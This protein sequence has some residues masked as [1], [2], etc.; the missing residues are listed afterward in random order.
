MSAQTNGAP[1]AV[2]AG[3]KP[4]LATVWLGG[5]SGCHM[6]LLDL[7]ERLLDLAKAADVVFSPVVDI[8]EFP[9]DV[10]VTLVEGAVANRDHVDMIK[11]VRERS[12]LVV[13]F[14]DC[15]VTGN[16]TALRNLVPV[17]KV[18]QAAYLD[19]VDTQPQVPIGDDIVPAL[20]KRVEPL[21]RL[22][23]V[24]AFIPGCPPSADQIWNAVQPFLQPAAAVPA[25][26]AV[27]AASDG[28]VAA[29]A[30]FG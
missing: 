23:K 25:T 15:A 5:C 28:R 24:D 20:L 18:L 22:V 16:V 10:D 30:K 8:K 12:K 21:H 6:S 27:A 4:R 2:A 14:G 13:A 17:D 11:T 3:R 1:A 26:A 7:D 9:E 29:V 19:L